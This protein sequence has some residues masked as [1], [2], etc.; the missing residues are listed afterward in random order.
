MNEPHPPA[1]RKRIRLRPEVRSRQILDA[2]LIEFSQHGFVGARIED[3]ASRAQLSKSGV[4]AHYASKEKI[5]EALLAKGLTPMPVVLLPDAY[6]DSAGI[7]FVEQFIDLAYARLTDP[8]VVAMLRLLIAES[9]RIPDLIQRWSK[10]LLDPYHQAQ[11]KVLQD[12]VSRGLIRRSTL[13]DNFALAYA[14]ALYAAIVAM[15]FH[16][17]SPAADTA[18]LRQAHKQFMLDQLQAP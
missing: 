5:F 7:N 9:A 6:G 14:P 8:D 18:R 13:T 3:I 10:E 16:D 15:V 1:G 12:A 2:A 11:E 17:E 4:Y